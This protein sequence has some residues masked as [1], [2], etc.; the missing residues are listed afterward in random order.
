MERAAWGTTAPVASVTIPDRVAPETCAR[1]GIPAERVQIR[2]QIANAAT[3]RIA[4]LILYIDSN[5]IG[6]LFFL[7]RC[8]G[9]WLYLPHRWEIALTRELDCKK[10]EDRTFKN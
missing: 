6:I 7:N 3:D 8:F 10:Q 4:D 1:A 5:L 2:R 9:H